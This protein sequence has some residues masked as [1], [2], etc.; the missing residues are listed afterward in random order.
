[1]SSLYARL[2]HRFG[3]PVDLLTRRGFLRASA[4]VGA[5]LLLS[6]R[7]TA[8]TAGAG[9]RVVIVGGGF[10]GLTAAYEL[11]SA[12]YDVTVIDPRG[13][14]GGRV[15]SFGDIVPG[16][17]V[18]GGAE[19][20]GS[21]HPSWVALAEKF[22][23]EFLD[24]SENDDFETPIVLGGRRLSTDDSAKLWE[25]MTEAL[26]GLNK[27][28]ETVNEDEPWKSP[29]APAL[30]KRSIADWLKSLSVSDTCKA[31]IAA[32]LVA[33][34]G[35]ATDKMSY[36][37]MLT[38]I[39][40]GG[41][42]K[43]WTETEVYRCKGGNQQLATRLAA[44]I[45]KDRIVLKLAATEIALKGDKVV[46]TCSDQR[47]L[48]CDDVI[49][50]APPSVWSKIKFDP[51]LPGSLK[52]QMG[53]ALKMLTQVK[54]RFWLDAKC[55]A[56]ALSDGDVGWTWES[57]DGQGDEGTFGFT[58][59]SGGPGA[60]RIRAR[61]EKSRLAAY[62]KDFETLLPG[63][64]A[65]FIPETARF[66]DWPADPWTS[67]GYSFAAPGEISSMGRT[68]YDGIGRLHFAGE[69]TCYKFVGYME[70]ALSSGV[71]VARQLARRDGALKG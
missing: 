30:D 50:T 49:V 60:E 62:K 38:A 2:N 25:E 68:L 47:T 18:E 57:T 11:K 20:I 24:V 59:F 66:M 17:I 43:Y 8:A 65:N 23:L 41:L 29:D 7:L 36:L 46:V 12:G 70:G 67:G 16:K 55:N 45:G 52:P 15:L 1:M 27:A 34:N 54:Q 61:D 51:S 37:A 28:S 4:A 26:N 58:G 5:G 6:N 13:R 3:R 31:G 53:T 42:D 64:G 69:H 22:E 10:A 40:G 39:K 32:Q 33:D 63:F 21:N 71:R 14:V 35:V 44:E 48:E 19:L 9:K 56:F